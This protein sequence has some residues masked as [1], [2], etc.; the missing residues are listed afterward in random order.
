MS[1]RL[2]GHNVVVVGA[3][4]MKG[5]TLGIGRATALLFAREGA[6]MMLVDRDRTAAEETLAMI[7]GEGGQAT[8]HVADITS[9]AACKGIAAAARAE[10]GGIDVLFNSVGILGPGLV[11]DIDEQLWNSVLDTNLKA[12]WLVTKHALGVMMEQ[13]RGSIILVSSIGAL[14][15]GTSAAYGISKAG[16]SRLVTSIAATYAEYNI[17]ANSIMPGLIDTPMAV[18]G[19]IEQIGLTRDELVSQRDA[20]TPMAYKGSAWDVAYAALFFAS[21]DSKFIS[22]AHLP[23]DGAVTAAR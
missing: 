21:D 5:E 14:R 22:G 18:D 17:R 11:T 13:R 2:E 20:R 10:L 3:G 23:V 12:M 6:N 9:D 4:Q 7:H 1:L 16:V 15:G 19:A 8:M